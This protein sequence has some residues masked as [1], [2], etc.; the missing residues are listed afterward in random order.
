MHVVV[1]GASSGIGRA[2]AE[3][4]AKGGA[5]LT[6]VARRKERL[7]SLAEEVSTTHYNDDS[8]YEDKR[9]NKLT[10]SERKTKVDNWGRFQIYKEGAGKRGSARSQG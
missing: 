7:E 5:D 10:R 3:R 8:F 6:L 1:T 4:Y 9:I 2:I